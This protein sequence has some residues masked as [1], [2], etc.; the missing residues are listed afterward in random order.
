M[1][2][3]IFIVLRLVLCT[4][5]RSNLV[6]AWTVTKNDSSGQ[7]KLAELKRGGL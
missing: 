3:D 4:Q 7:M 2:T 1:G 5:P 6:C